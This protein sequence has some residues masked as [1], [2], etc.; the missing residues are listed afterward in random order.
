MK[1]LLLVLSVCLELFS[2]NVKIMYDIRVPYAM[3]DKKSISGFTATPTINA[4]EKANLTYNLL[5]TPTKRQLAMIEI[6]KEPICGIGWF[7]NAKR[8]KFG[9]YTKAL[10]QDNAT[11]IITRA[12]DSRFD[13]IYKSIDVIKKKNLKLLLK[14][15]FSYGKFVDDKIKKY[16]PKTVKSL[17][18]NLN[19]INMIKGKRADYMFISYE[20]AYNLFETDSSLEYSM[21]IRYLTDMPKGN[22]RYLLC[23]KKVSSEFIDKFNK[24]LK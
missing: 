16:K 9:K 4:L 11:V 8:E 20:E 10:Y 21:K 18:N 13:L 15:G 7:K 23:S 24:Y 17:S 14:D 19:M 1:K 12:E 3:S 22:K 6:N 2:Q 5:K